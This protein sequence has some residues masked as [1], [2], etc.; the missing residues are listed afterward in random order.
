MFAL[1]Q[2]GVTGPGVVGASRTLTG[3][4][5]GRLRG[6]QKRWSLGRRSRTPKVRAEVEL[7]EVLKPPCSQSGERPSGPS[8]SVQARPQVPRLR[9]AWFPDTS[10]DQQLALWGLVPGSAPGDLGHSA[11][12]HKHR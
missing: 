4:R 3:P 8:C 11:F 5:K 12:P 2:F 1:R 6:R 7:S 10:R 9:P